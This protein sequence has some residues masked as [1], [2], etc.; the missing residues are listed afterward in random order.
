MYIA[1]ANLYQQ[2]CRETHLGSCQCA[3]SAPMT[4]QEVFNGKMMLIQY[5]YALKKKEV[6]SSRKT[7]DPKLFHYFE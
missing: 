5:K 7:F 1:A 4:F 6:S 3:S 2:A